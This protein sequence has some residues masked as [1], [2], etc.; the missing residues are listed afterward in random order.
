[1]R[2]I[3]M[4]TA[5]IFFIMIVTH[6]YCNYTTQTVVTVYC[7][8]CMPKTEVLTKYINEGWRVVNS[9][10]VLQTRSEYFGGDSQTP[11]TYTAFIIYILS[12]EI[13]E[14]PYEKHQRENKK[15]QKSDYYKLYK[16]EE[17]K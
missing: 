3:K 1:M 10:P 12:K 13:E 6:G 2:N 9:T 14:S 15:E 4:I 7:K 17:L 8:E 5:G 16:Q 11:I